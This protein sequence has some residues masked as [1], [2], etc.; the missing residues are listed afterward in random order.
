MLKSENGRKDAS[1]CKKKEQFEK[2]L[3]IERKEYKN[4][5]DVAEEEIVHK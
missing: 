3:E 1:G 2:E 5:T 4:E